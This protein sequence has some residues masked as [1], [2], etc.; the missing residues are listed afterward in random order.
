MRGWT[1]RRGGSYQ[2]VKQINK[3]MKKKEEKKRERTQTA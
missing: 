2:D 1:G 3:F